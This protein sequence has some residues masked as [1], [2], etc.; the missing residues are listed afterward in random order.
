MRVLVTYGRHTKT[1][2]AV[3]SIGRSGREVFVI[4]A[5]EHP[6]A[7][8]SKFCT[9]SSVSPSP[10][11][12]EQPYMKF[13]GS[14]VENEGID[15]LIPMDD[16]E[17]DML[18]AR[19]RRF[20]PR[21]EVAMPSKE[22]YLLARDK[23]R[24]VKLANE[25]GVQAPRSIL[26][27]DAN[28]ISGISKDIGYPAIVKPA[29]GSGS[30]GFRMLGDQSA[31]TGVVDL[32]KE[33]G[34]LVAQE[35]VPHGGAIGV[36][37]LMNKGEVR[38][39][40]AHRRLLEYPESGGPSII[41]ESI[42]HPEAVAA[43]RRLLESLRWHGIAMVEF[44]IDPRTQQCSLMEINPRFWGSL[45]LAVF[46]GMDFPRLLCDMYEKGDVPVVD[47]YPTG[48]RCVNVMPLGVAS[49]A[50]PRGLKR[51]SD[52]SRAA[53]ACRCLDVESVKDPMPMFGAVVTLMRNAAD[54]KKV[55]TFLGSG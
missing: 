21:C 17:C 30:R 45:P 50:A 9:G 14:L 25:L 2:S 3:R 28:A 15:L 32:I 31:L 44:R 35:Y 4:D 7:S 13:L 36:S 48:V 19:E 8:F 11:D 23:F 10:K 42:V 40:F 47:S 1:L 27:E 18:S 51:F 38:A 26:I 33:Y 46:C 29:R 6:L 5:W 41:R 37:Y 20:G 34:P 43:G 52:L 54:K 24:T 16:P 39:A 22:S 12:D 53:L 55:S 49:I